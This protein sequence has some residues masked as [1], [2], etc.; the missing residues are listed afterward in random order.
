MVWSTG[1]LTS[2]EFP[3]NRVYLVSE[4]LAL[5]VSFLPHGMTVAATKP[6]IIDDRC[7][8]QKNNNRK[9]GPHFYETRPLMLSVTSGVRRCIPE[10]RSALFRR[11]P[12]V[13]FSSSNR[14]S[15]P[16][17]RS[18]PAR[19]SALDRLSTFEFQL[20]E[21]IAVSPRMIDENTARYP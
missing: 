19:R 12:I 11:S 15:T 9:P 8:S 2:Y 10:R 14:V 18:R 17:R 1:F 7:G 21:A 3:H 6:K 20:S 4:L 5:I 13:R 16:D